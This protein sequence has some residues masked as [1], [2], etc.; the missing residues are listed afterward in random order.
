ME[1]LAR[2]A[3]TAILDADRYDG[4]AEASVFL[5]FHVNDC[6]VNVVAVVVVV[7]YL[8]FIF[9]FSDLTPLATYH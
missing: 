2:G 8:V 1:G 9:I 3:K 4:A 7:H 5:L 6:F